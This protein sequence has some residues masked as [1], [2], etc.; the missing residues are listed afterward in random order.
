MT[1]VH[2]TKDEVPGVDKQFE[3]GITTPADVEEKQQERLSSDGE[4]GV[5]DAPAATEEYPTGRRLVPIMVSLVLVVFL[6]ALDMVSRTL[7]YYWIMSNFGRQLSVQQFQ[8]LQT[9]F[10]V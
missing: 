10:V 7:N 1:S 6:V 3:S 4:K 8:R 9:S 5:A 2:S